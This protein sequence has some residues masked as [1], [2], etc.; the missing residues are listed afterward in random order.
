MLPTFRDTFLTLEG[1]ISAN[2]DR[3]PDAKLGRHC[4]GQL[5]YSRNF[6][7]NGRFPMHNSGLHSGS[8]KRLTTDHT[9]RTKLIT[10]PISSDCALCSICG[11]YCC[12][13]CLAGVSRLWKVSCNNA[14]LMVRPPA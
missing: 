13:N 7:L 9:P 11:R 4:T 12:C 2:A 1:A 6:S 14:V 10:C 3:G 5:P 8:T